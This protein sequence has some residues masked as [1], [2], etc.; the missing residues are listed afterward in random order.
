MDKLIARQPYHNDRIITTKRPRRCHRR[1]SNPSRG[2]LGGRK[3]RAGDAGVTGRV[4]GH[5]R[6]RRWGWCVALPTVEVRSQT[7][8]HYLSTARPGGPP[9]VAGPREQNSPITDVM[10]DF[11]RVEQRMILLYVGSDH[12]TFT[13]EFL[14]HF[15]PSPVAKMMSQMLAD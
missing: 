5:A 9:C 10:I 1:V 13:D 6:R 8:G 12:N 14:I 11:S 7:G 15:R 4:R 2:Q 3:V